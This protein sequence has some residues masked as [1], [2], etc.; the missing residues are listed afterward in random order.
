MK[1]FIRNTVIAGT[2]FT[3]LSSPILAQDIKPLIAPK[4]EVIP[5]SYTITI[6]QSHILNN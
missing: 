3:T 4:E 5:I 2:I 6:G 1:N